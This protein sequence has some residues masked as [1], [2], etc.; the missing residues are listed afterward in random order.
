MAGGSKPSGPLC[1]VIAGPTAVGKTGLVTTL[2]AEFPLEVISLDSRQIYRGMHIGTAQPTPEEMAACRH[3]LVD[4]LSPDEA[5]SA[6]RFRRDFEA[7]WQEITGRG[8]LPILAGG[9]GMYLKAVEEGFLELP[10]GSEER[11][12]DLRREIEALTDDELEHELLGADP[13]AAARLHRNDRYR[14]TRALEICRLAGRPFS[15]LAAE[16]Q[17]SPACGLRFPL[18][19][20]DR[21]VPDLD[22]RIA[23]RTRVMLDVGWIDETRGLMRK[24]DH[25]GP[26]LRSIGYAEIVRHLSGGLAEPDLAGT[27]VTVTRQY[28]KRQR[29]WF[30]PRPRAALGAPDSNEVLRT[31]RD[32]VRQGLKALGD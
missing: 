4:F 20:L 31:L 21:P 23:A 24:H 19:V 16:Q 7:C 3:H 25:G 15:E 9:A 17:H 8:K 1:P 29:T 12:P 32:L 26:G 6:Q 18:V 14:R 11:L 5:Y 30:R 2:A 28:A 22:A 27:I 13:T 10:A